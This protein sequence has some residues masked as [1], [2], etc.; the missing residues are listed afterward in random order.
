MNIIAPHRNKSKPVVSARNI[1]SEANKLRKLANG[2]FAGTHALAY[3]LHDSQVN[4][5]PSNFFV[6]SD[7]GARLFPDW[8]IINPKVIEKDNMT[9]Y[10]VREGCMSFPFRKAHK[11]R[12]YSRIKVFFQTKG[13]LGLTLKDHEYWINGIMAE[14]FQHETDHAH[15]RFIY[16]EK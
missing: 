12:R 2:K 9:S 14:I 1:S 5:A 10:F 4:L 13:F 16:D 8:L 11:I 15:S 7:I 6:L 3:A